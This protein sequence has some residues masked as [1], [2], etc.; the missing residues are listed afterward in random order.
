MSPEE[1]R[2][3]C[4]D[5]PQPQ[6]SSPV[7]PGHMVHQPQCHPAR[8]P[9]LPPAVEAVGKTYSDFAILYHLTSHKEKKAMNMKERC[10]EKNINMM[11][12]INLVL[13]MGGRA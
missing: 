2:R 3:R 5:S 11:V 4:V 8:P 7:Q 6:L 12:T 10:R 13:L 1:C 9:I